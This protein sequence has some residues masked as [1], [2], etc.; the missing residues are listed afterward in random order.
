MN[1][2]RANALGLCFGV[3]DA[4][5]LAR[6]V[7]DP[8]SVMIHG[9]LV[10]N[11]AVLRQLSERGFAISPERDRSAVPATSRVMITAHGISDR[12]RRRLEAAGKT[13]IDTTCP[14]VRRVHMG[15]QALAR[16]GYHVIVLG[17]RDHV[18]VLG[19]VEDLDSFSVV[20]RLEDVC[21]WPQ[22]KLGVV[23]QTTLPPSVVPQLVAAIREAN[24][25]SDI[26]CIDTVC[27]PTRD[28]QAAVESLCGAVDAVV[29]VGGA[30][31]NNTRHLVSLCERLGRPAYRV[32]AADE[33][34]PAWFGGCRTVGL[35]AGTSTL[36]EAIDA[37]EAYLKA[38]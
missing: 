38:L 19:I 5:A 1:V 8:A 10:H 36:D 3:R 7:E 16:D 35:T 15:A 17:R 32:E 33:I 34:D 18:E 21:A 27:Q 12:E 23:C 22:G 9:E 6:S 2:L 31:S 30:R 14:L 28:R 25:G 26:R 29:V 20:G 13:L 24:P 11:S 4:L 37:V